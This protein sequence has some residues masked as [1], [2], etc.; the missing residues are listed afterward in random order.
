MYSR[1]ALCT[2]FIRMVDSLDKATETIKEAAPKIESAK[3]WS[4]FSSGI[5]SSFTGM[6]WL[7]PDNSSPRPLDPL[8]TSIHNV[9]QQQG[10]FPRACKHALLDTSTD[11]RRAK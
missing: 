11:W 6:N 2:D 5:R 9:P 8:G 3:Q 1:N 7:S 4:N 10:Q